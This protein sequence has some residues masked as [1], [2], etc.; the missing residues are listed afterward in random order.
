MR[1]SS[2]QIESSTYT[3]SNSPTS[4]FILQLCLKRRRMCA[5]MRSGPRYAPTSFPAF[6]NFHCSAIFP[7]LLWSVLVSSCSGYVNCIYPS[8]ND[9]RFVFNY[10][11]TVYFT[12]TSNITDPYMNLWC[13]PSPTSPQSSTYGKIHLAPTDP[14]QLQAET[15]HPL[16]QTRKSIAE[17][18]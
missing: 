7:L 1:R 16:P 17:T 9:T 6:Y 10:I 2:F 14:P 3:R 5:V 11:D 8:Q 15:P 4:Q 13:A 18:R 12:W